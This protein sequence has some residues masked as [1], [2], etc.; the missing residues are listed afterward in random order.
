MVPTSLAVLLALGTS[1]PR[2]GEPAGG[3]LPSMG[4]ASPTATTAT[5]NA[6]DPDEAAAALQAQLAA[7][8]AVDDP[9]GG[10]NDFL[11]ELQYELIVNSTARWQ[12]DNGDSSEFFNALDG[13]AAMCVSNEDCGTGAVCFEGQ[14]RVPNQN[15]DPSG[16]NVGD[17]LTTFGGN[18]R[19]REFTATARFDTAVYVH[20]PEAAPNASQYIRDQLRE[21][22][23]NQIQAEYLSLAYSS[24]DLEVTLGDYYVTLGRGMV[25]GVRIVDDVAVDNKLR[26]GEAKGTLGPVSLHGFGGFLN[27]KNIEPGTGFAYDDTG[28]FIG[29]A[30][31]ELD[32]GRMLKLGAHGAF[33]QTPIIDD[34]QTEFVN[35]GATLEMPRPV[36]WM[37]FYAEIA[38]IDRT[39]FLGTDRQSLNQE[40][41]GIYSNLN[42]FFGPV[43]VLAEGK[44]YDN[45]LNILP[46]DA[47]SDLAQRRQNINRLSEP[48]TAERFGATILANN[49]VFGGRI[50]TDVSITPTV[51]PYLSVGHYVDGGCGMFGLRG[52]AGATSNET[53]D[54][55]E[56]AGANVNPKSAINA[57]FGGLRA[58]WDEGD[59]VVEGGYRGQFFY[60][61][62]TTNPSRLAQQESHVLADA[63]QR[64]G[65]LNAELYF[66]GKSLAQI[67]NDWI[68]G[69]V[70]FS[71]SHR[72]GW[73]A[74]AAYEYTSISPN[75]REHYGSLSGQYQIS[76][77]VTLRALIGGE[78]P[79]LKC[80]G[81]ACRL[82]PGFEGG[83][84]ELSMRL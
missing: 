66:L 7:M 53:C 82:F 68:E 14:C 44:I 15:Y 81:G 83:R 18:F 13:T 24:E 59:L 31:T 71:L 43:T 48:P 37:S 73:S 51:V 58:R 4:R 78:R 30:R 67:S 63:H 60:G 45:M 23:E 69:R 55:S 25:L 28:D 72:A 62:Q 36:E 34:N 11:D 70:A 54:D 42:L 77:E 65:E 38:R 20:A 5:T 61:Q 21:R 33:I 2:P 52:E 29:G 41:L 46:G 17:L 64:L 57:L 8:A 6:D 22:Y 19:W 74:T 47:T 27:I 56:S 1:A 16:E 9:S 75:S 76:P 50:R 80:S 35:L 26:G 49:T 3:A 39:R 10:G 32:L 40:G 84:L 12:V 79:G